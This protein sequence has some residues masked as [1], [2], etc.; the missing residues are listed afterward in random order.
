MSRYKLESN[1]RNIKEII[2]QTCL[3]ILTKPNKQ[4][5]LV[6]VHIVIIFLFNRLFRMFQ[7]K[8][9]SRHWKQEK[10][11]DVMKW[12]LYV[13]SLSISKHT[14]I[15]KNDKSNSTDTNKIRTN[16]A[17]MRWELQMIVTGNTKLN[18]VDS[19]EDIFIHIKI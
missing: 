18:L 17:L 5:I 11:I 16:N 8:K 13:K 4:K 9:N 15:I 2:W 6:V 12:S 19:T 3:Y 1:Q 7:V 10:K 14:V